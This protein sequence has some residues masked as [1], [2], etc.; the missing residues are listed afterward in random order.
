MRRR[1]RLRMALILPSELRLFAAWGFEVEGVLGVEGARE[2]A[3]DG[4]AP[5]FCTLSE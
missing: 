1:L 3:V 4:C 5:E 2:D